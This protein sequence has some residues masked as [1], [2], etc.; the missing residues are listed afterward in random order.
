V[1]T[2]GP[3]Q[4][5][6]G[7][8]VPVPISP[9][10]AAICDGEP[11]TITA[12]AGFTNYLWNN[13]ATGQSITVTQVGYYNVESAIDANGCPGQSALVEVI[14]SQFPVPNFTYT[15]TSG[16][17]TIVFENTSQNGF[18]YSWAFDSLGFS[19]IQNPTFTFP[20]SG[21]FYITLYV[22]N[23]CDTDSVT[24]LI[25]VA[26]V[27][28]E[29]LQ[30]ELGIAVYPNPSTND[31]NVN[32]QKMN[33]EA[34]ILNLYDMAG[35]FIFTKSINIASDTNILIEGNQLEKGMYFLQLSR[36]IK[37]SVIKLIKTE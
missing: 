15:Q 27:G 18:N 37:S 3:I 7:T 34:V 11:A 28:Y 30:Q 16:G 17:Y 33:Q 22:S 21:P 6:T 25:I 5:V 36:G 23:P 35:R 12:G 29:D 8:G 9:S 20:D 2:F 1:V 10:I 4:A 31:F 13:G 26:Q 19:P 24:K 14:E 32:I